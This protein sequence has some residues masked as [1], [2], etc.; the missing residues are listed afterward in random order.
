MAKIK[1][2][3]IAQMREILV[4]IVLGRLKHKQSVWHCGTAACVAGWN[5]NLN[6][7]RLAEK[8]WKAVQKQAEQSYVT[9][10]SG[11]ENWTWDLSDGPEDQ[12]DGTLAQKD[13]GL[14]DEEAEF[15]FEG[16]ASLA[17][18]IGLIEFLAA[19]HRWDPEWDDDDWADLPDELN[20]LVDAFRDADARQTWAEQH[21]KWT[22]ERCEVVKDLLAANQEKVIIEE[23]VT[24]PA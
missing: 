14:S 17:Q 5:T 4:G 19:G 20:A 12:D 15:M 2:K 7:K 21:D 1:A 18:Q 9:L 23:T 8:T 16:G 6:H 24:I 13:W 3:A 22:P 10:E 11:L